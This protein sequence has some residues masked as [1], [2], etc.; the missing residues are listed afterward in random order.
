MLPEPYTFAKAHIQP[1]EV[2]IYIHADGYNRR[3]LDFAF[4]LNNADS[5]K[6]FW[7]S[8]FHPGGENMIGDFSQ[9]QGKLAGLIAEIRDSDRFFEEIKKRYTFNELDTERCLIGLRT[10]G[11]GEEHLIRIEFP[12]DPGGISGNDEDSR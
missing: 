6:L 5:A 1:D 12:F 9:N 10:K 4:V 3:G 7:S 2:F 11:T 8:Y